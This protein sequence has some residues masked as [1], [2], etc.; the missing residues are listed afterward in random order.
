M[1]DIEFYASPVLLGPHCLNLF[2]VAV[3]TFL[4]GSCGLQC[5]LVRLSMS[6]SDI[7]TQIQSVHLLDLM[8]IKWFM[9]QLTFGALLNSYFGTV[10]SF[11]PPHHCLNLICKMPLQLRIHSLVQMIITAMIF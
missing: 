9:C 5:L 10:A 7:M 2:L 6:I 11:F 4:N 8:L 1:S 3:R